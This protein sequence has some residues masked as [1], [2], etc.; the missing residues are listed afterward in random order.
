MKTSKIIVL[1]GAVVLLTG[2]I[3]IYKA[4]A[5]NKA[6]GGFPRGPVMER[7]I[8]RLDLT[9][10]QLGRIKTELRAEKETLIPLVKNLHDTRKE[11]R[12]TI[13]KSGASEAEVRAASAKVAAVESDLAV[14][15]AKLSG[16]I[17]PVLTDEQIAKIHEFQ[18][19]SDDFVIHGLKTFGERLD[20]K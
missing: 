10:D 18:A 7:I 9:D 5:E 15:R 17:A 14:E 6:S 1:A 4:H 8:K 20:A 12:E 2:G 11:L 3:F 13:N 19:K 16:K